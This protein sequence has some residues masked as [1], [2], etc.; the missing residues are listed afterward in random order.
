MQRDEEVPPKSVVNRQFVRHAP[1]I[2]SEESY[3]AGCGPRSSGGNNARRIDISKQVAGIS[4]PREGKPR[5]AG[6]KI[7]KAEISLT[8]VGTE[9]PIELSDVFRAE[10]K[11]MVSPEPA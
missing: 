8:P 11:L 2:L 10:F 5:H 4:S 3:A 6:L 7:S 9:V 1:V